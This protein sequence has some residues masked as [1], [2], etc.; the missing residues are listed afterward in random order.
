GVENLGRA[1]CAAHRELERDLGLVDLGEYE[2]VDLLVAPPQALE[3]S[4]AFR[5]RRRGAERIEPRGLQARR[6]RARQAGEERRLEVGCDLG[7]DRLRQEPPERAARDVER[8]LNVLLAVLAR[9][10]RKREPDQPP[11]RDAAG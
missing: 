1:V 7:A 8:E 5:G 3:I 10:R 9:Q 4:D 11:R 6:S 2:S